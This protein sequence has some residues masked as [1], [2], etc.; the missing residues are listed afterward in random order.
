MRELP[1]LEAIGQAYEDDGFV[2]IGINSFG[3][4]LDWIRETAARRGATFSNVID[5]AGTVAKAYGVTGIPRTILIAPDGKVVGDW[6]GY[7][8]VEAVQARLAALGLE[9]RPIEFA[10]DTAP[11]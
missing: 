4:D 11:R 10:E 5:D 6:L 7:I 3:D 8:D 1:A 2:L 9:Q